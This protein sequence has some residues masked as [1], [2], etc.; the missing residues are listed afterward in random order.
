MATLTELVA[1]HG[2]ADGDI[3]TDGYVA[4]IEAWQKIYYADGRD[5]DEKGYEHR[6]GRLFWAKR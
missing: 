2:F 6:Q 3:N 1:A 5:F 4:V